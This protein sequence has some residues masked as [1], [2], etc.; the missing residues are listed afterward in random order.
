MSPY[1]I[2][3]VSTSLNGNPSVNLTPTEHLPNI[4]RKPRRNWIMWSIRISFILGCGAVVATI[5]GFIFGGLWYGLIFV[6]AFIGAYGLFVSSGIQLNKMDAQYVYAG[7][8][9]ARVNYNI[10]DVE[11]TFSEKHYNNLQPVA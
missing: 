3:P 8:T 5:V 11:P 9:V 4:D 2:S 10:L 6:P 7:T 1:S